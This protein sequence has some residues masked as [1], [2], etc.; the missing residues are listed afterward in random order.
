PS[1]LVAGSNV[2]AVEV[3]QADST[4][5]DIRF[6]LELLGDSSVTLT[7]GPYLQ[8]GTPTSIVVRWRTSAPVVGRVQFGPSPGVVTGSTQETSARMEHEVRLTGL[9]PETIYYYS[10]GTP[11][12]VIAGDATF[13]FRTSPVAG[14]E[15]P[16]RMWVI[17]DS[18]T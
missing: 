4:S 11:T 2:I 14:T 8:L 3:H 6:D 1:R 12:A 13:H 5:S 17:G 18:G 16:V 7:R 10:V 15:R 9:A